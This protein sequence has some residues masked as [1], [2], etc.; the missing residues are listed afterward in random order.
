[1][2]FCPKCGAEYR[3]GFTECADCGVPLVYEKPPEPKT[4]VEFVGYDEILRTFNPADIA[5]VRSILDAEGITYFM[6]GE[7]FGM[8]RPLAD[9]VGLM[10]KREDVD[11][12]REVLKDLNLKFKGITGGDR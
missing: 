7:N 10:V 6:K 1:M 9:P 11:R 8:V 4:E 5:I 2:M 12:A 3:Q